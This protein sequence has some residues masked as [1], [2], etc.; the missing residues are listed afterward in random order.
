MA[1]RERICFVIMPFGRK[2]V[3]GTEV[4]FN[5]IDSNIFE[6][7]IRRAT[8]AE[9]ASLIPARTD[10]DAFSSSI[11]QEMLERIMDSRMAFADISGLNSNVFY[12]IAVR[13]N[14]Q[15]SGTV[16]FR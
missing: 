8:T 3:G 1:E 4:D 9:G 2:S 13:H 10:V 6:H 14:A 7:A 11:H 5:A 16:V 15:A 12:E